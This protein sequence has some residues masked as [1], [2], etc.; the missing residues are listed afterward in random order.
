[1]EAVV[2]ESTVMES[3][4]GP[5]VEATAGSPPGRDRGGEGEEQHSHKRQTQDLFHD[6]LLLPRI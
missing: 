3:T 6:R 5:T 4:T 2:M 1:M